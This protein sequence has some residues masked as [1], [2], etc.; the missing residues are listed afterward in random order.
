MELI[1]PI[2]CVFLVR[3][4]NE[5]EKRAVKEIMITWMIIKNKNLVHS[6]VD[7]SYEK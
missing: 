3:P 4:K 2:M 7:I 1:L 5:C 6:Y